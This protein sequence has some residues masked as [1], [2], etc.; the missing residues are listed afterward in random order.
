M[1]MNPI[2]ARRLELNLTQAELAEMADVTPQIILRLE[3]GL[4]TRPMPSVLRQLCV[5]NSSGINS[6]G[7]NALSGL[8]SA[9]DR[10]VMHERHSRLDTVNK[11]DWVLIQH[12]FDPWTLF[13]RQL[14]L[15]STTAAAKFLVYQ[16]SLL[17]TFERSLKTRWVKNGESLTI[18]LQDCGV[19]SDKIRLLFKRTG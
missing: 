6:N 1:T 5:G 10:W 11:V 18:A 7:S 13:K 12:S 3:Q 14:G 17:Q 16:V 2:R 9:Y 8:E 4:F 19:P 15:T